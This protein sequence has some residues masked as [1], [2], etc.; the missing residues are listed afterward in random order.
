MVSNGW[1]ELLDDVIVV[2]VEKLAVLGELI[3]DTES[4]LSQLLE[5]VTLALV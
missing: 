1:Q 4:R 5:L 3:D 2:Q